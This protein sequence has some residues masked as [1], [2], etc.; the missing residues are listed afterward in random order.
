MPAPRVGFAAAA[1]FAGS[2]R[3]P[4]RAN[5][6]R[7]VR[8]K[9]L[10]GSRSCRDP[11]ATAPQGEPA[12]WEDVYREFVNTREQ[13]GEPGDGLTYD[14]FVGKLRKNRDTLMQKYNCRSVR[15]AVYVKEGK[16][17]LKATPVKD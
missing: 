1:W 11:E 4:L 16:A 17:A 6:T 3:Y 10:V 14:K 5:H 13:C 15:F 8:G 7:T 12:A 2:N 9:S